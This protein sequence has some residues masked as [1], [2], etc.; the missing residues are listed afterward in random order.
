MDGLLFCKSSLPV[1]LGFAL[2]KLQQSSI[3][4]KRD[5]E[6]AMNDKFLVTFFLSAGKKKKS[7]LR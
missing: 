2:E 1:F 5:D 6:L 3:T 4:I 7:H